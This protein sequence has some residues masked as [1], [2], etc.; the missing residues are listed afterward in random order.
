M[1]AVSKINFSLSRG[2]FALAVK[3][4]LAPGTD[5]QLEQLIEQRLAAKRAAP[6]DY[7]CYNAR[8]KEKGSND[9][10]EYIHSASFL[11]EEKAEQTDGKTEH[12]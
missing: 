8:S 11:E 4:A 5:V 2:I 6:P 3:S 7:S 1:N 10:G 9:L 12:K